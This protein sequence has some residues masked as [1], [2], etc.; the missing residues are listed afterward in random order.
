MSTER[1]ILTVGQ[2]ITIWPLLSRGES[3]DS[4]PGAQPWKAVCVGWTDEHVLIE[5]GDSIRKIKWE[6]VRA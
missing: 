5:E 1:P 4:E 2:T 3:R 6:G